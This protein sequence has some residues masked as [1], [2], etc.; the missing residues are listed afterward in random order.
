MGRNEYFARRRNIFS[1]PKTA[2]T[3]PTAISRSPP[4][5]ATSAKRKKSRKMYRPANMRSPFMDVNGELSGA[6]DLEPTFRRRD[7]AALTEFHAQNPEKW[8]K[9][10]RK[11]TYPPL[12]KK[13][14]IL[15]NREKCP[16]K[17]FPR[18]SDTKIFFEKK[19]RH[20][21]RTHARTDKM[22]PPLISLYV[23]LKISQK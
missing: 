20:G 13:K 3:A 22:Q 8:P 21:A 11:T 18:R 23:K 7:T 19:K 1:R 12:C 14:K 4:D 16:F 2:P 9:K 17:R 5:P 6:W 15:Q 10:S